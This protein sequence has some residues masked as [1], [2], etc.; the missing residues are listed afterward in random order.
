MD[1]LLIGEM[2]LLLLVWFTEG[3]QAAVD[4]FRGI[5][6]DGILAIAGVDG[7]CFLLGKGK[8]LESDK[9]QTDRV[10]TDHKLFKD[11]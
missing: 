11:Y 3:E 10:R 7:N 2:S 6:H 4:G 9:R 5:C 1:S 8:R